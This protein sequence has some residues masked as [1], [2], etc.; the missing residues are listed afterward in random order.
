[1]ITLAKDF[2]LRRLSFICYAKINVS[3]AIYALYSTV[4][5]AFHIIIVAYYKE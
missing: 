3:S 1:M 2:V 4:C 5:D